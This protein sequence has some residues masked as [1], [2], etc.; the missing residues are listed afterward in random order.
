MEPMPDLTFFTT[1][2]MTQ[3]WNYCQALLGTVM[4]MVMI[5]VAILLL[6][7]F[8]GIVLRAWN[9]KGDSEEEDD[10]EYREY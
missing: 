3:F 9:Q 6:G 7:A 10:V 2:R 5:G 1:D 8:M 4:P